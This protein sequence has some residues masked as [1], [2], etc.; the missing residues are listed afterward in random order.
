MK[1]GCPLDLCWYKHQ[2]RT[3]NQT[4]QKI[5]GKWEIGSH[6]I[7]GRGHSSLSQHHSVVCVGYGHDLTC[8]NIDL[9]P[10][11]PGPLYQGF[12]SVVQH[13]NYHVTPPGR[14][15]SPIQIEPTRMW[16]G[17]QLNSKRPGSKFD[18]SSDSRGCVDKR[19]REEALSKGL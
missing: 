10:G 17:T 11:L 5:T 9:T 1:N 16:R 7:V 18:S 8:L 6:R 14:L 19:R 13:S 2:T 3:E 15:F 4:K 12:S